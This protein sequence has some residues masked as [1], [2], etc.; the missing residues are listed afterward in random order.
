MPSTTTVHHN[1]YYA[2]CYT[3]FVTL[4]DANDASLTSLLQAHL[5]HQV[6][7]SDA[8]RFILKCR[9][10]SCTFHEWAVKSTKLG[11]ALLSVYTPHSC[12]GVVHADLKGN[13]SV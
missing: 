7:K 8:L 9:D 11:H 1:R 4:A 5:S 6:Y 12:A 3:T 13:N 2:F 10:E